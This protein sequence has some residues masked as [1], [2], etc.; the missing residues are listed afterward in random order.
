MRAGG[1]GRFALLEGYTICDSITGEREAPEE[2]GEESTLCCA[3]SGV[4]DSTGV[5]W[6]W[7]ENEKGEASTTLGGAGQGAAG[8]KCSELGSTDIVE[9]SKFMSRRLA[10]EKFSRS[11]FM[12]VS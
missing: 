10:R 5:L 11:M 8:L 9:G 7:K 3:E 6:G 1:V 2:D 12:S 4:L